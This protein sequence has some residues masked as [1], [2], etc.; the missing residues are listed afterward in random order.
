MAG[1]YAAV[2][3][4]AVGYAEGIP[5]NVMASRLA[6]VRPTHRR[7]KVMQLEGGA[8]ALVDDSKAPPEVVDAFID[9][10][11]EVPASRRFFLL[12]EL[13]PTPGPEA[14]FYEHFAEAIAPIAARVIV[15]GT[16]VAQAKYA[17]AFE[18]AGFDQNDCD[19][20]CLKIVLG[21]PRKHFLCQRRGFFRVTAL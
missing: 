4:F 18:V 14:A 10:M 5:L 21:F 1:V 3:A 12:G 20:M 15:A 2:A 17:S 19:L 16:E 11:R 9:L 8:Y 13:C 7:N 6:R